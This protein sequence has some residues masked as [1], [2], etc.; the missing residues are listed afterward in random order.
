MVARSFLF[1][2]RGMY[3]LEFERELKQKTQEAQAI[4]EKRWGEYR[5]AEQSPFVN[6]VSSAMEY[7]ISAGGKRLRPLLM[8]ET[9]ELLS[10]GEGRGDRRKALEVFMTALE[11]IHTYSL[12]HDDLPAMD[13]DELRRGKATTWKVYGDG[14]G[15]LA[16]DALMNTAFELVFNLLSEAAMEGSDPEWLQRLSKCGALLAKKAG[17]AGM[18]GGQVADVESEKQSIP[19]TRERI[20]FI[21]AKKTAAL[22]E[23]AMTIGAIL[24]GAEE[25]TAETVTAIANKV[26]I[27]FQIQDDILDVEGDVTQ[28]GKP[29]GSDEQSGKETY[30]TMMGLEESRAEVKR[31]SE[32]A[33][34]L[35]RT[36]PGNH[37]FLEKW[38]VYLIYR[39]K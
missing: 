1:V 7:S 6:T 19:M 12:V 35:L 4:V 2:W 29:I 36:L 24:A 14:M 11:M 21:H 3:G 30:V 27:A 17:V 33:V 16:G 38:F 5:E 26:G 28:L 8:K 13:N 15:V 20:L 22:I 37:T 23:A 18:L 25:E 31:L 10:S 9:Y 34:A 32:E 39:N